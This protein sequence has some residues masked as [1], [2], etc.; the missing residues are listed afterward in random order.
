MNRHSGLSVLPVMHRPILFCT[1]MCISC[2]ALMIYYSYP[3]FCSG[4]ILSTLSETSA[5]LGNAAYAMAAALVTSLY[6]V[7][8]VVQTHNVTFFSCTLAK[9]FSA[10]KV[11]WVRGDMADTSVIPSMLSSMVEQLQPRQPLC[12]KLMHRRRKQHPQQQWSTCLF[13]GITGGE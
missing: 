13:D 8:A 4:M 7:S 2:K 9:C 12:L 11:T 1:G 5:G 6:V 10:L 3:H